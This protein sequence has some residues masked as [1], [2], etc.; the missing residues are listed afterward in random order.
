MGHV[1]EVRKSSRSRSIERRRLERLTRRVVRVVL[2]GENLSNPEV[3]VWFV[4][5]PTIRQLNRRYRGVDRPTDVM[6]F[7]LADADERREHG[8]V[9][10]DVV[11]SVPTA[12]RQARS[13]GHPL[14]AELA[15]LLIHGVLHLLGYEH[16]GPSAA[17]RVMRRQERKYLVLCNVRSIE[18]LPP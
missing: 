6:A 4:D 5:D 2:D 9:L 14:E 8:V 11:V 7:P 3:G 1:I 10:G 12:G 13:L 16:E 17:R 18:H 15:L